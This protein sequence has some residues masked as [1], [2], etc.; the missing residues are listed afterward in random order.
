MGNRGEC[1]EKTCRVGVRVV[2]GSYF[3]HFVLEM[4]V[5]VSSTQEEVGN[6]DM[7]LYI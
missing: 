5:E 4:P 6:T 1:K 2:E 3:G 7:D